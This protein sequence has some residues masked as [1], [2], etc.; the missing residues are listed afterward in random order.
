[1]TE[2]AGGVQAAS[3][4]SVPV[5]LDFERFEVL[6]FDCYGTLIDWE[7]GILTA[8]RPILATH[9]VRVED[10][11]ALA[12]YAAAESAAEAGPYQVYAAV[13]RAALIGIGDRLGFSP[14]AEEAD[15][16]A[17]SILDWPPFPDSVEALQRL[18]RRYGLAA[19]TNCDDALFAASSRRLGDP[20]SW[21]ITAEQLRSYKPAPRN[22]L[23]AID[24]IGV[25]PDRLL[26]V[27]QS[28]YH[29]HVPAK[30]LGLHTVWVN[31]L[32]RREGTGATPVAAGVQPDLEVP[33][34]A[35]LVS[36]AGA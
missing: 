14:V 27:A 34:L 20:F 30:Q 24:R 11:Q 33:D 2:A 12:A 1:M 21:V 32:G 10:D 9:G 23:A 7:T 18:G 13:L 16:F 5:P 6:S 17:A 28:L 22:F 35:T 19:L 3:R 25:A 4:S 31:R 26:H 15:R 8:L 29:D 36:L